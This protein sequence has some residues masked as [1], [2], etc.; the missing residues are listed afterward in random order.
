M[1]EL[2]KQNKETA[3]IVLSLNKT[4]SQQ[5]IWKLFRIKLPVV[6]RQIMQRAFIKPMQFF[7]PRLKQ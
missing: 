6:L 7:M 5:K 4:Y 2:E 1:C 3:S